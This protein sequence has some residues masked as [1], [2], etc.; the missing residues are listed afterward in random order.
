[1][2]KRRNYNFKQL[3]GSSSSKPTSNK[4]G[5]DINS[6]SVNERLSDLRKLEGKDAAAQKRQLADSVNLRSV[7]PEVRGILGVPDSAPPRPKVA[8]LRTR[9]RLRTP[10]PAPPKSWLAGNSGWPLNLAMRGARRGMK[11]GT[12][13]SDRSRPKQLLRFSRLTGL[14]D[15][16][17]DMKPSSLI[18]ITLKTIA[19]SWDSI[20][21]EDYPALPEIPLR[22]RLKLISYIDFYGPPLDLGELQALLQGSEDIQHLDLAGL[23]GHGGLTLKKIMRLL[24]RRTEMAPSNPE[25]TIAESWDANESFEA[26]L[27]PTLQISRFSQLTHLCLSHP[28][29]SVLWR[30]LLALSKATPQ[31]T[32]LSLA[33]WPRPTLTPN[34]ATAS[35]TS[36]HSPDVTAGGSHYYSTLDEDMTEPA[37]L[38]RQLSGNL[39]CLQWA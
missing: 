37:S 25:E 39:L 30:D 19:K 10:G 20:E 18:H 13:A 1:M 6:P 15:D 28:A 34:L 17:V 24:D 22:L 3:Q 14:V 2:P 27:R 38:L 29:P 12:N 4:N 5:N 26:A 32:H 33:Y 31:V 35:V 16:G 11:K 8:G 23:V 36:Q 7:P 21:E 9:E